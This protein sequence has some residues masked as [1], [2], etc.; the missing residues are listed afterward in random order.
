MMNE[1]KVVFKYTYASITYRESHAFARYFY[2]IFS[3]RNFTN[4]DYFSHSPA[5]T[6]EFCYAFHS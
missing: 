4:F 2:G 6:F 1:V 5:L 3:I